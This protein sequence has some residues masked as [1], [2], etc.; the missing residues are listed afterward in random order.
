MSWW[1]QPSSDLEKEK[2]LTLAWEK[3]KR[4]LPETPNDDETNEAK[5]DYQDVFDENKSPL[6]DKTDLNKADSATLVRFK[7]I[8]P[9]TA[10]RIITWR[11]ENGPFTNI[12][13][14]QEIRHFPDSFFNILKQHLVVANADSTEEN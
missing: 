4:N 6:P 3:F 14:L 7:G 13:Q 11:N 1:V 5:N 2:E 10:K 9:A 12:E 8:G